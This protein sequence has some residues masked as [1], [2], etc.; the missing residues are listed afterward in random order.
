LNA[1]EAA[2]RKLLLQLKQSSFQERSVQALQQEYSPIDT[3]LLID[4]MV[5]QGEV[6][7]RK[8]PAGVFVKLLASDESW[9]TR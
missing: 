8:R 5:D 3:K 4:W 9:S 1:W 6:Q 7:F 2:R